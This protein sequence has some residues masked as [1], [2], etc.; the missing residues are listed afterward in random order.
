M[1]MDPP[2]SPPVASGTSPPAT[3]AALP[4]DDP[5]VVRP[6]R[7]GLCVTPLSFVTLTFR[8]AELGGGGEPDRDR[9]ARAEE[10]LDDGARLGGD[11]VLEDERGFGLRPPRNRLELLDADGHASEGERDVG[12]SGRIERTF[13]VEERERVEVGAFDR[14]ERRF[15]LLAR[16]AFA[17]AERVDERA[18]VAG[19]G[20]LGH[21]ADHA[22]L[23]RA[24]SAGSCL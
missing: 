15:Q 12:P 14:G 24:R 22:T 1:R 19:P 5:P 23:R 9:A 4:A 11:A 6:C 8:P 17:A 21:D 7:H 2:P 3:A 16:R 18:R 10:P 20:R 13:G